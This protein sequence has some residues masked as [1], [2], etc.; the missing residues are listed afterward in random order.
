MRT[1]QKGPEPATLQAFRAVPGTTYDGKDFTPVKQD[2]RAA[3]LRDQL[4]LCCYC[5]R[6]I[7]SEERPHP[8]KRDAPPVIRMK[9]EHWKSQDSSPHLQLV[10]TNLL[11]ACPGSEGSSPHRQT[12]DTRKGKSA[13]ALN[14]L[15]PAHI[16]TLRC[17]SNGILKSTDSHF[18]EDIEQRL[19]LNDPILVEDRRVQIHR[20]LKQL[21]AQYPTQKFPEGVL[22]RAIIDAET[23]KDGKLPEH[24]C[25][26][27]LRARKRFGSWAP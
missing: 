6:R 21:Q 27:R 18:Q 9:V 14:P 8:T 24:A 10:W 22:R 15:D 12:C 26:L 25:V 20:Q 2:V 23:V 7:S 11:G 13:I 4:T 3:L 16:A 17:S 19:N 5:L 1:I